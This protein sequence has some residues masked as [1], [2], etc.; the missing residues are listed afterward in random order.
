MCVQENIK[1]ERSNRSGSS[2]SGRHCSPGTA[3]PTRDA[4]FHPHPSNHE[5]LQQQQWQQELQQQ[6]Q[7]QQQQA[8]KKTQ[9]S[10][11]KKSRWVAGGGAKERDG[12]FVKLTRTVC[13]PYMIG[14]LLKSLQI[15]PCI[16]AVGI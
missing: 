3:T 13:T 11:G 6:Q 14:Y 8:Q 16:H 12:L 10:N 7:Q 9:S 4:V 2:R 5:H 1:V 15:V